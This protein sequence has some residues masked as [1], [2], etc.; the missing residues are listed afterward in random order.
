MTDWLVDL[1]GIT[2]LS[3]KGRTRLAR[4]LRRTAGVSTIIP[5]QVIS[6]TAKHI[7]ACR[8]DL[9]REILADA[10]NA[11]ALA[12]SAS[13]S[14]S[15]C[16]SRIFEDSIFFCE[17]DSDC[18]HIACMRFLAVCVHLLFVISPAPSPR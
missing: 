1:T 4:F 13:V 12:C 3:G 2:P 15:A 10:R 6:R 8:P 17:T 9:R 16:A 7:N 18:S 14:Y 5:A 11:C